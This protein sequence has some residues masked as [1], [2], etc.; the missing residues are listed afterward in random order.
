MKKLLLTAL[1]SLGSLLMIAQ[2]SPQEKQA[3]LDFYTA[4]NG[5][6]WNN[7]W[8]LTQPVSEWQGVTV[9]DNKVTALRLLFNNVEGTLP[10]SL[11]NLKNLQQ[12]ELSFNKLSGTIPAELGNLT[13]LEMLAFNG[14]MLTGTLPESL[15]NLVALKQLHVS[16]NQ[17]TGTLPQSFNNLVQL[18]V[19]NVFDNKMHGEIPAELMSN[20]N[21]KELMIAENKFET[22]SMFSQVLLSN[23]GA[24]LDLENPMF[25]TQSKSVIAIETSDDE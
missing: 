12:L 24:S 22:S 19:F 9:V 3:L 21:L 5:A 20:K 1:F 14:N 11:G 6:K 10:A 25:S 8:D 18:E 7:T 15:G 17:L 16:S 13:K 2:V 23:S 4:T